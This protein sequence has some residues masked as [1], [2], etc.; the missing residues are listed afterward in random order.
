MHQHLSTRS[1]YRG[2]NAD[3]TQMPTEIVSSAAFEDVVKHTGVVETQVGLVADFL[4]SFQDLT[5]GDEY[6]NLV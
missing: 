2:A 1:V 4:E 3:A 5:M 6:Q